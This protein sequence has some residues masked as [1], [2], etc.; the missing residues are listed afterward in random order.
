M[1]EFPVVSAV[2]A[3]MEYVVF[4]TALVLGTHVP[5]VCAM[6]FIWHGL[7][8]HS[9]SRPLLLS[10]AGVLLVTLLACTSLAYVNLI[11][12]QSTY[13]SINFW[14]DLLA[15]A[16]LLYAMLSVPVIA[17]LLIATPAAAL[18]VRIGNKYRVT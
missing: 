10:I 7:Q 8:H 15:R 11:D 16:A 2:R 9:G 4:I 14:G 1:G 3:T 18:A 6:L 12:L 17:F 13:P 5:G